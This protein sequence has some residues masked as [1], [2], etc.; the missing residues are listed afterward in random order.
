MVIVSAVVIAIVT[1]LVLRFTPLGLATRTSVDHPRNA[2]IA[3]INTE[4]VTAD[5][6]DGRHRCSPASPACCSRR[7]SA[8][9]EFQFTLLLVGSFAAV[10]IGRMTSLPSTFIGAIAVGSLQQIW[11][12]YQPDSGFF[13]QGVSASIPF[14]VMLVFLIVLQLHVARA[15]ARVVHDGPRRTGGEH[16]DAPPL[17]LSHGWRRGPARR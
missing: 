1:T 4:G 9:Q 2:A 15:A 11:V 5:L 14:I 8:C 17:P 6:V 3:G 7:S 10:V 13:S 16:G 12:K